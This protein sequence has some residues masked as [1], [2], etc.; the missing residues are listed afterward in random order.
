ML[1][2]QALALFS[3]HLALLGLNWRAEEL[4]LRDGRPTYLAVV[5]TNYPLAQSHA[6]LGEE[7]EA[8]EGCHYVWPLI[9]SHGKT[10]CRAWVSPSLALSCLS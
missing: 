5:V 2:A 9:R 3:S 10:D 6:R 1:S 4:V 7:L 8:E